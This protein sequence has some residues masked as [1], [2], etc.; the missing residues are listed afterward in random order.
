MEPSE[1]IGKGKVNLGS[2]PTI[3]QRAYQI[4][5]MAETKTV[6]H[7][8][9]LTL[10]ITYMDYPDPVIR[11]ASCFLMCIVRNKLESFKSDSPFPLKLL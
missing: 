11:R 5:K 10:Y 6:K 3:L 2:A 7:F 1:R 9:F 4:P 8:K